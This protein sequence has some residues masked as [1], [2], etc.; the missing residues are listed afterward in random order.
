MALVEEG[1][2]LGS[3]LALSF[4]KRIPSWLALSLPA[5]CGSDV[6][7]QLLLQCYACL[8]DAVAPTSSVMVMD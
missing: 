8:P 3:G 7:A 5:A 6:D 2:L 4:Q 1:V